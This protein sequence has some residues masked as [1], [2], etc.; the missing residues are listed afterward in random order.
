MLLKIVASNLIIKYGFALGCAKETKVDWSTL[1]RMEIIL[2][3]VY[4]C[5]FLS[6]KTE[7]QDPIPFAN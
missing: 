7:Q 5:F 6:M 3:K 1:I 4:S 2:T